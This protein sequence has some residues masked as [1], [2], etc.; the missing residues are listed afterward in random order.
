[1]NRG[2]EPLSAYLLTSPYL[3][4]LAVA[5]LI[6]AGYAVVESFEPSSGLGIVGGHGLFANYQRVFTD[7]RFDSAFLHVGEVLIVWLPIFIVIVVGLALLMHQRPGRLS[8][9]VQF[10]LYLP[11]ALAGIA[12]FVLWLFILDPTVSPI[13]FLAHGFGETSLDQVAQPSHLPIILAAM[14][15]FLGT[16]TWIVIV[17]GGLNNIPD[18]VL[19]AATIDGASS[20]QIA[21]KV[22]L[23]LIRPW[24]G[25]LTLVNIA[26]GFQLFLEPSV[27]S[28][29]THGVI[30]PTWSPNELSYTYAYSQL[31]TGG[32]AALS[33]VLLAVTMVIGVVVISRSKLLGEGRS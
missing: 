22:K 19:E 29:V 6:P 23:P 18:E 10:I 25:Y 26:Y 33:V 12:N 32:A 5:G 27:M 9:S 24:I 1:M 15:I 2:R 13:R 31:D 21:M 20:W 30:S 16:G 14:L 8:R 11:G 7:Y 4:L 17:F 28:Q 3:I